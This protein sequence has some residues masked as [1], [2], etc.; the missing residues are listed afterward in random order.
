MRATETLLLGIAALIASVGFSLRQVAGVATQRGH[1]FEIKTTGGG[2]WDRFLVD[3]QTGRTWAM[4]CTGKATG[5][6]CDGMI[7]W[8]EMY[9]DGVTPPASPAAK[10][11]NW[12]RS[13][14]K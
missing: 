13:S 8:S 7:Y 6:E 3:K 11:F 4:D 9:V 2:R 10:T 14:K 5:Q 1:A 12:M